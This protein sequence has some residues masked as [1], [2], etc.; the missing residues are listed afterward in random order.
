M[1]TP[2]VGFLGGQELLILLVVLVFL[3][4][5][6]KLP[7]LAGSIGESVKTFKKAVKEE[8]PSDSAQASSSSS[9][10]EEE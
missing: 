5:A 4:G 7:E 6:K 2:V 9:S 3:F 1:F 8:A 10:A